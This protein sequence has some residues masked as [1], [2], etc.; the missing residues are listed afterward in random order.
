VFPEK[1]MIKVHQVCLFLSA[2]STWVCSA[3]GI[4][5]DDIPDAWRGLVEDR[6]AQHAKSSLVLWV[7]ACSQEELQSVAHWRRTEKKVKVY[8]YSRDDTCPPSASMDLQA[9]YGGFPSPQAMHIYILML[10]QVANPLTY[11]NMQHAY[12]HHMLLEFR[13]RQALTDALF[14][15]A[16]ISL[17]P[18][19]SRT[20]A[21]STRV[22]SSSI[23]SS[24]SSSSGADRDGGSWASGSLSDGF[25]RLGPSLWM[26]D[27]SSDEMEECQAYAPPC[28]M[29]AEAFCS[30]AGTFADKLHIDPHDM[31]HRFVSLALLLVY[32]TVA[33]PCYAAVFTCFKADFDR[34]LALA[35]TPVRNFFASAR[36]VRRMLYFWQLPQQVADAEEA[37]AWGKASRS[38]TW[39]QNHSNIVGA[40]NAPDAL[41][42]PIAREQDAASRGSDNSF[43]FHK[44]DSSPQDFTDVFFSAEGVGKEKPIVKALGRGANGGTRGNGGG[45]EAWEAAG[46][47]GG[48]IVEIYGKLAY[49]FSMGFALARSWPLL[50]SNCFPVRFAVNR[51]SEQ[52]RA[53]QTESESDG[54][55]ETETRASTTS[56]TTTSAT[57]TANSTSINT[58]NNSSNMRGLPTYNKLLRRYFEGLLTPETAPQLHKRDF[59]HPTRNLKVFIYD[60]PSRFHRQKKNEKKNVVNFLLNSCVNTCLVG[61]QSA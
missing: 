14:F 47:F 48:G 27:P 42:S 30:R 8:V 54:K 2:L 33:F 19:V 59:S 49:P 39:Q 4:A 5:F 15:I 13:T 23:C 32:S 6:S 36:A 37:C 56:A 26:F 1:Y 11:S 53:R 3:S 18:L 57:H 20:A 24:S 16:D 55:P 25:I 41:G 43:R 60:L 50:L 28:I 61:L 58:C 44:Q 51:G 52:E 31:K 38:S 22:N 29:D 9:S 46:A 12:L 40:T 21:Q 45:D 34:C 10:S 35:A 7:S 17:L